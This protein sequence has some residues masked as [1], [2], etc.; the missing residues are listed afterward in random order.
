MDEMAICGGDVL[1]VAKQSDFIPD[2]CSPYPGNTNARRYDIRENDLGK[3][4][5]SCFDNE[6]NLSAIGNIKH[7]PLDQPAVYGG[8]E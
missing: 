2:R 8:I 3:I 1:I 5:A 4:A 7:P 6:A